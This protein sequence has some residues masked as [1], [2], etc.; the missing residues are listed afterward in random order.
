MKDPEES[1]II[2][3]D[4]ALPIATPGKPDPEVIRVCEELLE[5]A[6]SGDICGV[7]FVMNHT[8]GSVSSDFAGHRQWR[9]TIGELM[10]HV[11]NLAL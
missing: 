9:R 5:R 6:S 1:N 7:T 4:L 11:T 3:M 10:A 2:S 8:D